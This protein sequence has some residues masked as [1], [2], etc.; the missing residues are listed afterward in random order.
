MVAEARRIL[1]YLENIP[2]EAVP[3]KSLWHSS[4]KCQ[5]WIEEHHPLLQDKKNS[6][7]FEFNDREI[8]RA[9]G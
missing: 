3:P 9:N 2:E 6:G 8:E 4:H 7:M 5:E 1:S